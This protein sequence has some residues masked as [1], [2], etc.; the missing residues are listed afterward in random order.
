M[1]YKVI[2]QHGYTK[3]HNRETKKTAKEYGDMQQ[4]QEETSQQGIPHGCTEHLL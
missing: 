1:W 4:K 2:G 3:P